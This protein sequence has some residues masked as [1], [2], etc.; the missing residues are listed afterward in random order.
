MSNAAHEAAPPAARLQARTATIVWAAL[1]ILTVLGWWFA[2]TGTNATT[3][4][5]VVAFAAIKVYLI[6]AVF[7]GVWRAPRT[8]HAAAIAWTLIAFALIAAIAIGRLA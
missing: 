1:V 2:R 4:V 8:W 3:V 6:L 5:A 7:M